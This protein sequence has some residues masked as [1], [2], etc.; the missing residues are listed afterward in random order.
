M[1]SSVAATPTRRPRLVM[2]LSENWTIT[3]PRDLRALVRIA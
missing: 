3:F 2:V 1:M